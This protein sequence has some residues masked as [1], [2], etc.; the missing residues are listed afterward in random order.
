MYSPQCLN[1]TDYPHIV[2]SKDHGHMDIQNRL[3]NVHSSKLCRH[4]QTSTT[5]TNKY[6]QPFYC[7]MS[8]HISEV[9]KQLFFSK[10]VQF[11]TTLD[12]ICGP[13]AFEFQNRS[14][15]SNQI[16][17][18]I[19]IV[20]LGTIWFECVS[21]VRAMNLKNALH[22]IN[23]RMKRKDRLN[24]YQL[25]L[26][27]PRPATE[28]QDGPTRNFHEKCRKNT[29]QAEILEP[30]ENTPKYR[31]NTKNN[32]FWYFQGIFSVFLGYLG[33]KFWES[34]ISGRGVFFRY[35]SWKFQVGPFRGSVAGRGLLKT[36]SIITFSSICCMQMLLFP[37]RICSE[38]AP[39]CYF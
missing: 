10:H 33:G 39:D 8:G 37:N 34:R 27:T 18:F 28:P 21:K 5:F 32:H 29:P 36:T 31:K 12:L 2:D 24:D 13:R 16:C 6:V 30:Q 1:W 7:N 38:V 4:H 35:F 26:R 20:S 14:T 9:K 3:F 25:R 11:L 17:F 23:D 15:F 19:A 22:S